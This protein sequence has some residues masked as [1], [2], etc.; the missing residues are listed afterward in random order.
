M[1]WG[2]TYKK[3]VEEQKEFNGSDESVRML[4]AALQGFP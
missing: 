3:L 2:P 4:E 1:N